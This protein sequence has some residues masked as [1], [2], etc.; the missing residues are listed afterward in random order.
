LVGDFSF[1]FKSNTAYIYMY[2]QKDHTHSI[3]NFFLKIKTE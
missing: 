3:N 1:D 2:I